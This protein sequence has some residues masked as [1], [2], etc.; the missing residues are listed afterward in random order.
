MMASIQLAIQLN[1]LRSPPLIGKILSE[2]EKPRLRPSPSPNHYSPL[3]NILQKSLSFQIK[4]CL[5][6]ILRFF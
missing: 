3:P 1:P 5:L 4:F 2:Q 6:V